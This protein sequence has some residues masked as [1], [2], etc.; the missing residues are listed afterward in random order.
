MK[1]SPKYI[2][3]AHLMLLTIGCVDTPAP[4]EFKPT[5]EA[6]YLEVDSTELSYTANGGVK[7]ILL[8]SSQNWLFSDFASWLNLSQNSGFG[9]ADIEIA[10]S[11]NY[12][13]DTVRTSIFYVKTEDEGWNFAKQIGA[14]QKAATP[15]INIIPNGL[16]VSGA[17]STNRVEVSSNT[18]WEATCNADWVVMSSATDNSYIDISVLENTTDCERVAHIVLS[19]AT[20]EVFDLTQNVAQLETEQHILEYPQAGGAYKVKISSEVAWAISISESYSSWID[21]SPSSGEAGEYELTI[22]VSPNWDTSMRI[23]SVWFSFGEYNPNSIILKQDGVVLS[24]KESL[25]FKALGGTETI[26]VN[27]NIKWNVLSK[28]SWVSASPSSING[29][30]YVSITAENNTNSASRTGTVVLGIEGV[31]HTAKV[32]VYQDG[33][34]FAVNNEQIAFKSTGGVMELSVATNDSWEIE[35]QNASQWLELSANKGEESLVVSLAASDNPSVNSR[36]DVARVMPK[37]CSPVEVMIRQEPRYL[38]INTNGVQF[39]SKGGTSE[40]IIVSTDGKYEINEQ[41]EWLSLSQEGNVFYVTADVNDS[42]HIRTGEITIQLT[43]LIEGFMSLRVAVTQIAPGG[44]FGRVDYDVDDLWDASYDSIF[45][46]TID[47]Y[48]ADANW[49]ENGKHGI[50]LTIEGYTGDTKWD[51]N[52]GNGNLGKEDFPDDN[53]Y[54]N[55]KIENN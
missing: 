17:A 22:A 32:T 43:D 4:D 14:T 5:E 45:N 24:T 20:T 3:V 23:G 34:Y 47:G 2:L 53:N 26:Y 9:D 46:I 7:N 27:S 21:V 39:F 16:T 25:S 40:P 29:S 55:D 54:D 6:H 13:A 28:P 19:G 44:V 37:D 36:S 8:R 30:G 38:T 48:I 50:I 41:V 18:N 15:Y 35:L 31:T 11:K 51:G 49:D 52:F 10:A 1:K 42:G 33:K 12:S